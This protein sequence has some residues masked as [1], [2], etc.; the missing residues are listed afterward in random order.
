M[1]TVS[2]TL[3]DLPQLS[4]ERIAELRTLA[5]RP[6]SEIDYSDIPAQDP[7]EWVGAER[8][9][10]YCPLK[11]QASIRTDKDVIPDQSTP[12]QTSATHP[13]AEGPGR[14]RC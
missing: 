8:G 12:G 11:T 13:S 1:K 4:P 7:V 3:A 2:V 9:R 6:D 14:R 5:K 10:F